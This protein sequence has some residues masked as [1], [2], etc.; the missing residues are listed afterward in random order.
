MSDAGKTGIQRHSSL[1]TG[2]SRFRAHEHRA[3]SPSPRKMISSS[4]NPFASR[5]SAPTTPSV[6]RIGRCSPLKQ[7]DLPSG[8]LVQ[9]R[10]VSPSP[11]PPISRQVTPPADDFGTA[12]KPFTGFRGGATWLDLPRTKKTLGLDLSWP[13][14]D[15]TKEPVRLDILELE[16]LCQFRGLRALKI[17][18][19]LQSYQPYIWQAAWLNLELEELCLEMALEPTIDSAGHAAQWRPICDGWEMDKNPSA[20]PVY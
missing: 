12:E 20:E 14:T 2:V 10:E 17:T 8:V 15:E 5:G 4:L 9:T 18:G 7:L 13:C 3:R 16:P 11:A 1:S 6:L 19:M